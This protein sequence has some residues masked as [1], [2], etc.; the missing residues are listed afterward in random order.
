VEAN[1]ELSIELHRLREDR[2]SPLRRYGN[3]LQN[4]PPHRISLAAWGSEIAADLD[5]RFGDLVAIEVGHLDYP[6]QTLKHSRDFSVRP[7]LVDPQQVVIIPAEPQ[8]VRSG[9]DLRSSIVVQNLTSEA[10]VI[11][12]NGVVQSVIVDPNDGTVVGSFA[13][14][15]HLPLVR[16]RV[17]PRA[18]LTVPILVGTAS[19]R[20]ELGYAVPV[21]EWALEAILEVEGKDGRRTPPSPRGDRQRTLSMP[22]DVLP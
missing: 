22:I 17:D 11:Q 3:P 4:N 15:Q 5:A 2:E 1:E 14:A 21:G 13:G 12:T 8:A 16:F 20:P 9:R 19:L 18:T 6:A 7:P 10:L